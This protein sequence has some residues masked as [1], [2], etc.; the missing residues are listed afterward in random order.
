M[1][2]QVSAPNTT[3]VSGAITCIRKLRINGSALLGNKDIYF[4]LTATK[5]LYYSFDPMLDDPVELS[6]ANLPFLATATFSGMDVYSVDSPNHP[7]YPA[8]F[9]YGRDSA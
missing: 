4:F 2:V 5:H 1:T 9:L 8:V 6:L 7:K 3:G